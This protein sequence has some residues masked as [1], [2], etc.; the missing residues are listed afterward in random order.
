MRVLCVALFLVAA[1]T[2]AAQPTS[3]PP[4]TASQSPA[5]AAPTASPIASQAC[6]PPN[7]AWLAILAAGYGAGL[8]T[9]D[10]Y[11]NT[12]AARVAINR[13]V[14]ER[15]RDRIEELLHQG[16]IDSY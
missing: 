3:S 8:Q 9:V 16:D 5:T 10:F 4:P 14:A 15:T 13:W 7:G 11:G 1:C 6:Y 2:P 12:E